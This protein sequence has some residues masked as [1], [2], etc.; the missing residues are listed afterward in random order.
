MTKPLP[1]SAFPYD[2]TRIEQIIA[3]Y[4]PSWR[5]HRFDS[6][7]AIARGGLIPAVMISAALD[8]PLHA[9]AY[10]R[11]RRAA[12]WYSASSP[13]AESQ[14]L[15]VEDIAGRGHTLTDCLD[16]LQA[17]KITPKTFTLAYDAQSRI[18]P[19]FGVE[20]QSG[21]RAW[22]PWERESITDAFDA[23]GNRP[24]ERE[25]TYASWAIDLDGVLLADL[26]EHLYHDA[27]DETLATRDEL[28]PG[29][30]LPDL[31]LSQIT[32]ITGRPEQDRERTQ[33]WLTKHGFH[34]PLVMRDP[35]RHDVGQT[36]RHKALALLQRRHTH[37][38]ESDV[39]QALE[40]AQHTQLARVYWWNG[41]R[42]LLVH[43]SEAQLL[44]DTKTRRDTRSQSVLSR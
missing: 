8:I 39:E 30:P 34:G 29:N 10:N 13:S 22:F 42:A 2:Y 17:H 27:L 44:D 3:G 41:Q 15:L 20:I 25:Y 32:I 12:S 24:T 6:V 23:T 38:L 7:V 43:A 37:F 18:I 40:I 28:P 36:A 35:A 26:P 4:I 21:Y 14:V 11:E 16:F 33:R 5:H 31:H 1:A 19:E 9:L